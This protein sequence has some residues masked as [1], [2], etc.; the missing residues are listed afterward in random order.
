MLD[1]EDDMDFG[2]ITRV[3]AITEGPSTTPTDDGV[4]ELKA[5]VSDDE[6]KTKTVKTY[7]FSDAE[8]AQRFKHYLETVL[9]QEVNKQIEDLMVELDELRHMRDS[10]EY[11]ISLIESADILG[12]EG[13]PTETVH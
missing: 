6:G 3:Y 12:D 5:L 10:G 7:V 1:F 4:Y 11:Y 2:Q 8:Q 9:P 13:K